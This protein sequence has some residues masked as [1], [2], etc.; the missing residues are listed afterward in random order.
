MRIS[1]G[2]ELAKALRELG[3]LTSDKRAVGAIKTGM[4]KASQPMADAANSLAASDGSGP[5]VI[6]FVA[7]RTLTAR[8]RK[9]SRRASKDRVLTYVGEQGGSTI[10]LIN[11]FG[12]VE[13]FQRDAVGASHKSVGRITAHPAMRPAFESTAEAVIQR[14]VPTISEVVQ[15]RA[16]AV[17]K[18]NAKKGLAK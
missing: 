2:L 7:A 8:Q 4:V 12:T 6:R 1:G 9:E 14:L 13:R 18:K 16:K 10:G 17:A 11:E 15:K 3:D 5:D